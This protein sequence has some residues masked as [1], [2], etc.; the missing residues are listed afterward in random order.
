[1]LT[2]C[3]CY[4]RFFFFF[5]PNFVSYMTDQLDLRLEEKLGDHSIMALAVGKV[6]NGP[7]AQGQGL[8]RFYSF[9]NFWCLA[10]FL[11]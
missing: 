8:Q 2:A 11:E 3:F 9:M 1:M 7:W 5:L 4:Y 6:K 10:Q